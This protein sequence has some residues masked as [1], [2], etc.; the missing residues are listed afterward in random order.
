[1]LCACALLGPESG[2][3]KRDLPSAHCSLKSSNPMRL[4]IQS[5]R[6]RYAVMSVVVDDARYRRTVPVIASSSSPRPQWLLTAAGAG[7]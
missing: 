6:D 5:R 1:V 4:V 7:N 2:H 3:A